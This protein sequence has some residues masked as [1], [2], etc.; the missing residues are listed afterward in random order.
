[1]H[2]SVSAKPNGSKSE[3]EKADSL[4]KKNTKDR[5]QMQAARKAPK[6]KIKISIKEEK[7]K[8]PAKVNTSE[9]ESDSS[10]SDIIRPVKKRRCNIGDDSDSS[11]GS[12]QKINGN[13]SGLLNNT[14]KE[15]NH[16][17][18]ES[19]QD[20]KSPIHV[21]LRAVDTNQLCSFKVS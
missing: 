15:E 13:P 11:V 4:I 8:K 17:D 20:L 5:Q 14:V 9:N 21:S 16:E 3:G 12:S 2:K 18:L 1:M 6:R 10:G 7:L 19:S